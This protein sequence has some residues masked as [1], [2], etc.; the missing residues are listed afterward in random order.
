MTDYI[1][2]RYDD[3]FDSVYTELSD[4]AQRDPH[5]AVRYIRQTLKCLYVRQGNDWTGRGAIG[6]AGL[7]ASVAAHEAV[8]A[9]L[10]SS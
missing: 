5:E 7:D 1:E 10:T 6:N 9:E 4:R 2:E 3:T 8:L